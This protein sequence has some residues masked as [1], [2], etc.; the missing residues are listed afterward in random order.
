M[1][2]T[3]EDSPTAKAPG[4]KPLQKG[5]RVY[6]N[7]AKR[8]GELVKRRAV[9]PR[10]ML[11]EK[12]DEFVALRGE[13]LTIDEVADKFG[14]SAGQ[15]R[16][17]L[18]SHGDYIDQATE[19]YW[20]SRMAAVRDAVR[21][22]NLTTTLAASR[23]LQEV[24]EQTILMA[25]GEQDDAT[26]A[27]RLKAQDRVREMAGVTEGARKEIEDEAPLPPGRQKAMEASLELM[28]KALGRGVKK[29][30]APDAPLL[31]SGEDAEVVECEP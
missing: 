1:R 21:R 22:N 12:L 27:A 16:Q 30:L 23:A 17:L 13:G 2:K 14:M 18:T 20:T 31:E 5:R 8:P 24:N 15:L 3:S 25:K 28:G 26:P 10:Q 11:K 29:A 4:I 19:D 6:R 7:N 9:E